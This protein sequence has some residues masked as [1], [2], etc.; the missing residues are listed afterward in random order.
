MTYF[1]VMSGVIALVGL[2]AASVA[3]ELGLALF[4]YGLFAFG[5][6]FGFFLL[7]HHFDSADTARR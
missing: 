4:G 6:L 5:V 2:A 3:L 1:L 7:K